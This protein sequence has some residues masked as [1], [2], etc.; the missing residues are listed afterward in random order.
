MVAAEDHR[1]VD[2]PCGCLTTVST[3]VLELSDLRR[4]HAYTYGIVSVAAGL[5][6]L[7][8]EIGSLEWTRGFI[9][10][11]TMFSVSDLGILDAQCFIEVPQKI[12][13]GNVDVG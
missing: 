5:C 3:W 12:E 4:Q 7:V 2:G 13:I 8:M 10:P 6:L 1:P 11:I 9:T